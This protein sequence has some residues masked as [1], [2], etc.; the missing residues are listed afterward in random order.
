[1]IKHILL[2]ISI[3]SVVNNIFSQENSFKYGEKLEYKVYYNFSFIWTEAGKV[4]FEIKKQQLENIEAFHFIAIG[5]SLPAYDWL[6]RVRDRYDSFATEDMKPLLHL[7]NTSEG[8]YKVNNVYKFDN[9]AEKIY[10]KTFNSE[11]ET[12]LYDTLNFQKGVMDLVSLMYFARNI[13]FNNFTIGQKIGFKAIID[14]EIYNLTGKY[15]GDEIVESMEKKKYLC[16]KFSADV[17]EGSIFSAENEMVVW[18]SK[19]KN[20]VP[21]KVLAEV[22]VGS[23]QAYL[24]T[25]TNLK[26]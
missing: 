10:T 12:T 9:K 6:F 17:V 13:D 22:L 14:G 20:K 24:Y 7:R 18:V 26:Y 16:S 23:V 11:R 2:I 5:E 19:D 21:I 3:L 8:D 4:N 15:L 25:A 1:M